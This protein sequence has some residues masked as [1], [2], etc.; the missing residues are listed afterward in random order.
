MGVAWLYDVVV[1]DGSSQPAGR[2][3]EADHPFASRGGLKLDAALAAA[4]IDVT[5]MVCAD[6]GSSTGG[7]TSCLLY[8]GAA[9]VYAVDTGYGVLDY[10]LRTDERVVVMERCNA[11]HVDP[12]AEVASAAGLDLVTI[13]LGWTRQDK[14]LAAAVKWLK[15]TGSIITL[16]KPHYEQPRDTPQKRGK[17]PKPEPLTLEASHAITRR[18]LAEIDADAS[19]GLKVLGWC[20]SPIRGAKGGNLEQL[21]W[22]ER[23]G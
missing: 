21:A 3:T 9:K 22:L 6:L 18:V 7:F 5:G 12:Q 2:Y 10:K 1:N 8:R 13:D 11:L 16:V 23:R 15:P 17:Q 4:G 20:D 19:L 14:A